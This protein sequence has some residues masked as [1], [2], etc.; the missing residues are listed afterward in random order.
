MLFSWGSAIFVM[1]GFFYWM[2]LVAP[3]TE[4]PA[5]NTIAGGVTAFVGATMFTI[6]G[7]LLI[8][9]ATNENQTGCFGWALEQGLLA[10]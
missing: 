6:G 2:P 3:S 7:V 4:F 8:V 10:F 1:S 9:E 5:E